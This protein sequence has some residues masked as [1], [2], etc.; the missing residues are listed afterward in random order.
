LYCT[1]AERNTRIGV[2]FFRKMRA[3]LLLAIFLFSCACALGPAPAPIVN[4]DLD[5]PA[6]T[7]WTGLARQYKASFEPLLEW[8]DKMIP[9]NVQKVKNCRPK[10]CVLLI[11]LSLNPF[12][13]IRSSL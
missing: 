11:H 12:A 7:R 2:V 1:F 13:F 3:M 6:N 4:I 10:T 8:L 9:K 5:A